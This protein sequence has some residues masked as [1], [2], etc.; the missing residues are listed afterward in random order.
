M[1][2]PERLQRAG[3][4]LE[5]LLGAR[6]RLAGVLEFGV[7]R[8]EVGPGDGDLGD[9]LMDGVAVQLRQHLAFLYVAAHGLAARLNQSLDEGT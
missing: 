6:R 9:H 1:R 4:E 8:G 7:A 5:Q 3:F 2:Q